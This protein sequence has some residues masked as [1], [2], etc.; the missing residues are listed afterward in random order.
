M[1]EQGPTQSWLTGGASDPTVLHSTPAVISMSYWWRQEE[2][3]AKNFSMIQKESQFACGIPKPTS[4]EIHNVRM[5]HSLLTEEEA[6]GMEIRG[7]QCVVSELERE[8]ELILMHFTC[9]CNAFSYFI[10][11]AQ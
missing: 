7:Q 5:H 2:H 10:G 11:F 4:G 3:L 8:K 1:A 9:K 6:E